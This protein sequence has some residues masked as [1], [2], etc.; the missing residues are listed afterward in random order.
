[1]RHVRNNYLEFKQLL[2][3]IYLVIAGPDSSNVSFSSASGIREDSNVGCSAAIL[4]SPTTSPSPS[5]S[6]ATEVGGTKSEYRRGT[7]EYV[8]KNANNISTD[9]GKPLR[10]V[11]LAHLI[12]KFQ[13]DNVKQIERQSPAHNHIVTAAVTPALLLA[14]HISA[15]VLPEKSK[16]S[17]AKAEVCISSLSLLVYSVFVFFCTIGLK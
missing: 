4:A 12:D 1:M 3:S 11:R 10:E 9:Y 17:D 14:N 2:L 8:D 5:S 16:N 13:I 6:N 7:M 15:P